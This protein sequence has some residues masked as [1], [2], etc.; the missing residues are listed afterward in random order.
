MFKLLKSLSGQ[1]ITVQYATTFAVVLLLGLAMSAYFKR[2]VQSRYAGA[3]DYAGQQIDLL[4]S[5]NSLNLTGRFVRQY[6]PYYQ[7]TASQKETAGTV[8]DR[9]DGNTYSKEYQQY[10]TSTE[11]LSN[12]LS[13]RYAD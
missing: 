2:V 12:Q 11:V 1:G 9:E 3:R 6:E 4:F 13:P 10:Q 7:E 5:D 8:V